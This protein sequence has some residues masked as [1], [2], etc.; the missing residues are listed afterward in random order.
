MHGRAAPSGGCL[1]HDVGGVTIPVSLVAGFLGAG[2]TTVVN[3][4]LQN[5][6]GRRVAAVVNDFGAIDIDAALLGQSAD[7]VVSL[8]NGCICCSLQSDLIRALAAL[9]RSQP[10]PDAIVIETSGTSDPAEIMRSLLDPVVFAATPLDAV[11]TIVD[12]RHVADRPGLFDDP[13]W[14]SQLLTAD[15]VVLSKTDL[16]EVAELERIRTG[17]ARWKPRRLTFDA[18]LGAVLPDILFSWG[19]HAPVAARA[20]RPPPLIER[21][22]TISWTTRVPLSLTR[23]QTAIGRLSPN[24]LRAKG[25][26]SFDHR[27]EQVLLFQLVGARA[28]IVATSVPLEGGL[29]GRL[30]LISEAGKL[31]PGAASALLDAARSPLSGMERELATGSSGA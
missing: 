25:L 20:R 24:L 30:V 5:P 27:P 28:T 11:V 22:E 2:K 21:F 18:V 31:D 12:A 15:L 19:N 26:I 9:A 6:G 8:K 17:L 16:V 4:L 13:L 29:A 7:G 10:A 1:Q 3:R 14:R 23:F